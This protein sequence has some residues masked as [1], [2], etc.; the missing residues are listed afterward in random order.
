MNRIHKQIV[1]KAPVNQ[2]FEHF[3]DQQ[4]MLRWHG[5]EVRTDPR[6]GGEYFVR[7]ENNT[8]ITGQFLTVDKPYFIK[9]TARY[10]EVDSIVTIRLSEVESGTLI[11]LH[12]E[13]DISIDTSSFQG[14]WD[15]FL[16]ILEVHLSRS[17]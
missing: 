16:G 15:Y 14:G 10:G 9:Y 6:P 2:V 4:S 5:K 8:T 13:F 3:T 1:I 12:Q 17:F 7:F 11:D